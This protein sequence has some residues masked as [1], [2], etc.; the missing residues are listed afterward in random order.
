MKKLILTITFLILKTKYVLSQSVYMHEAQQ[1]AKESGDISF[2]GFFLFLVIAGII[3]FIKA[4]VNDIKE[5]KRIQEE[6]ILKEKSNKLRA[7]N[8]AI[9]ILNAN[10]SLS[11][12]IDNEIWREGFIEATYDILYGRPKKMSEDMETL[13]KQINNIHLFGDYNYNLA[14]KFNATIKKL[15]YLARLNFDK[16]EEKQKEEKKKKAL[17]E[18]LQKEKEEAE[19]KRITEIQGCQLQN[20]GKILTKVIGT[21]DICVPEGVEIIKTGAFDVCKNITSLKLPDSLKIIEKYAFQDTKLKKIEIPKGV[22]KIENNA[23]FCANFEDILFQN[24]MECLPSGLFS[25]CRELKN[26]KLPS[27]LKSIPPSAFENC[28]ILKKISIPES[29]KVIGDNAFAGCQSLTEIQLPEN[30]EEL[31]RQCFLGC[32]G[33]KQIVIPRKIVGLPEMCF[34]D[35]GIENVILNNGLY[36]IMTNAFGNSDNLEIIIPQTVSVIQYGAF[37]QCNNLHLIVPSGRKEEFESVCKYCYDLEI[38]EYNLDTNSP[39]DQ[40]KQNKIDKFIRLQKAKE[41]Y[42][43]FELNQELASKGVI[44]K[45]GN[46]VTDSLFDDSFLLDIDEYY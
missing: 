34:F 4:Y 38:T 10:R 1:D 21:G 8:K 17:E 31:G 20:G 29:V 9:E 16:F 36:C 40:D 13:N 28:W 42:D 25:S 14:A 19:F 24:S 30:L 7:Q 3:W 39:I 26:I 35:S 15:G 22:E 37:C 23:F 5:K 6:K 11:K 46:P 43:L 33:L 18:K 27:N 44:F 45:T 2:S 12:Y 32:Y 41:E